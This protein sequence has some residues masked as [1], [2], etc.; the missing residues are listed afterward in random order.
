MRLLGINETTH[1]A[2]VAVIEDGEIL[3]AAHAERYSK[4]KNDWFN[5]SEILKEALSFWSSR[6]NCLLRR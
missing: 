3:F 1:D 4:V 5:N 6:S 2:A